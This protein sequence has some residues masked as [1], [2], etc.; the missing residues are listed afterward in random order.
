MNTFTLFDNHKSACL[1][2]EDSAY[3]GVKRVGQTVCQDISLVTDSEPRLIYH[4]EEA[5]CCELV[6]IGTCGNS[7]IIKQL[8]DDQLIDIQT[9]KSKRECYKQQIITNPFPEYPHIKKLL[10]IIGNDKR[11]T[12]YGLFHLSELCGVSPLVYW[13]DVIPTKKDKI[14]L[15]IKGTE[16]Q[17][18]SVK[19]RGFFINDEWPAFWKWCTEKFGDINSKAYNKVF[20]LVLRLKG[21]YLW[22][23]MWNSSFWEDGPGIESARLANEYGVIIGTSHH[24]PL[25]RAGVEWQRKYKKYGKDNT[26]SFI[27][28]SKAISDFWRDGVRRCKDFENV[29]TIGMRGENDSLLLSEGCSLQDNID[30]VKKAIRAQNKILKEELGNNYDNVPRMLAIYKEVEDFYFGAEGLQGLQGFDEIEDAILL[31]SDD[32]HGNLRAIPQGEDKPHKGGYG[33]YYHFDYH[34]G[35]YSFEWIGNVKLENTW[36]QLTMA[37]EHDIRQMWIVNVGDIKGNEYALNYFMELAYNYNKW[38]IENKDSVDQ[39]TSQW[40]SEQYPLATDEQKHDLFILLNKYMR[41]SSLRIPESLNED[42]F[43]NSFFEI[44]RME[45]EIQEI[46]LYADRL[47]KTLPKECISAF[48]SMIY[49]PAIASVNVIEINIK[50]AINQNLAKRGV[51]YSNKYIGEIEEAIKNETTIANNFHSMLNGKWNHMLESAHTGFRSWDD[52]GWAYPNA[53][54]VFPLPQGKIAISFRGQSTYHLGFHWQDI[55]FLTNEEMTRPDVDDIL[56]DIDSRGDKDFTFELSSVDSNNWLEFSSK[57]GVC[58]LAEQSRAT[59]HIH[60]NR[61]LLSGEQKALIHI[62]I[63]FSNGEKTYSDVLIKAGNKSLP[64]GTFLMTENYLCMHAEHYQ[65]NVTIGEMGWKVIPELG[66]TT[67][68]IKVFPPNKNWLNENNRPYT[69]YKMNVTDAGDYSV[70]FYLVP[71]NPM[72]K[73]TAIQGIYGINNQKPVVFEIVSQKFVSDYTDK[74]WCLGVTNHIRIA[75]EIVH[76]EEGLNTLQFY[77]SDA[78]VILE[79]ILITL[80][81]KPIAQTYLAPKESYRF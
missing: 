60:C 52:K 41:I 77:A 29:I 1:W 17:E 43:Q 13:G 78:N 7:R 51:L 49:Y 28:N 24:E 3:A 5:N 21:N 23:A 34:G 45:K 69:E 32:N 59:V 11:G 40:I 16:T 81:N 73:G 47:K 80:K 62:D 58:H 54:K 44:E 14:V 6:F 76:L 9:L 25:C 19:Y 4:L 53:R 37:Y 65:K 50:A 57:K 8:S 30:V 39:F 68:A 75:S 67:S 55:G 31:L 33:L 36:E 42:V 46:R 18:P 79:L 15:S 74:D 38:G 66:R 26:W 72:I 20:E 22:P 27:T 48:E 56:L 70:K 71:R 61:S 63:L 10:V 64:A 2:M 12:I 35:P